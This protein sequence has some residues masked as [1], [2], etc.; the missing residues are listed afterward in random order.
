M[1]NPAILAAAIL[2]LVLGA[3]ARA[4]QASPKPADDGDAPIEDARESLPP[5]ENLLAPPPQGW[6]L[7]FSDRDDDRAVYDYVPPGQDAEEW[8]EMMTVQVL[9]DAKSQPPRGVLE[10]LRRE[11]ESGCDAAQTE[12]AGDRA[13]SGYAGARQLLLCGRSKRGGKGEAALLQVVI[14][15]E[16]A[17]AVQHAWRGEAFRANTPPAELR[18]IA[19]RW[20]QQL[21]AIGVCDTRVPGKGCPRP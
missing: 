19:A 20:H 14:G 5:G 15:R 10:R 18:A 7:A 8:R 21:D 2:A 4:Q 17:Y 11:F 1:P 9:F 12:P 3:G 6:E 16:A 13:V